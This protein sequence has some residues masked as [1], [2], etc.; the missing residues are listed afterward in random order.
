MKKLFEQ[1]KNTSYSVDK[2]GNVYA[3]RFGKTYQ[4]KTTVHLRGYV[5]V[6]TSLR[7]YQ[8]HRLVALAF[9]KNK[10]NKPCVNHKDGD[11]TNNTV[12]NLEWV[13]YKENLRHAQR[14]GLSRCLGKNEGPT[15]Y[16]NEQCKEVLERIKRGMT[17]IEAGQIYGM[18]YS[19]VAHLKRGSRRLIK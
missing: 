10:Y 11:K 12:E 7:N 13:T 18:P 2:K 19:T 5:Y 17:Y 1:T 3:T 4:K 6:R 8:L 16:T 9:I 14:T 15:K